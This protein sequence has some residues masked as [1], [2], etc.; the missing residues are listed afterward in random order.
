MAEKVRPIPEGYH[1]VTPYLVV[2]GAAAAIEFYEKAFGAE[3]RFRLAGPDG[4][5]VMHAELQIGDSIIMLS[6]EAPEMGSKSPATLDG[7]PVTIYLYVEDVDAVFDRAIKAGGTSVMPLEDM[8][9][10]DRHG[11]LLDPFGH[12][13]S[14]AT[15]VE[16]VSAEEVEKRA[17][18]ACEG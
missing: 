14:V 15:H 1:A 8:F 2:R 5:S 6:D 16:D 13:W 18:A 10:G 12:R 3:V 4:T 17:A 11:Q 9:W 7:T